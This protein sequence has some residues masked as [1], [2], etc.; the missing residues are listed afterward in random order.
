MQVKQ[1][2]S[3]NF[4]NIEIKKSNNHISHRQIESLLNQHASVTHQGR[5]K[6]FAE[7]NIKLFEDTLE[8]IK[9]MVNSGVILLEYF[10]F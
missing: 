10:S 1:F 3:K 5:K 7:A 2:I 8:D 4:S 6:P 9:G